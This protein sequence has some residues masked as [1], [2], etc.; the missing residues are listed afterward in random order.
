LHHVFDPF[1]TTRQVGEGSGLGL[2]V[3]YGVVRDHGGD[4]SVESEPAVRT[5]FSVRLPALTDT[6]QRLTAL[7]AHADGSIAS[8]LTATLTGWG[9]RVV[10]SGESDALAA[11]E[12]NRPE[13]VLLDRTVL[14]ANLP[15]WRALCAAMPHRLRFLFLGPDADADVRIQTFLHEHGGASVLPPY[16]LAALHQAIRAAMEH[17]R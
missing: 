1:F 17:S 3:S 11:V 7:V 10:A 16:D 12:R 5:T 4:I 2:S 13:L 9:H 15:G 6:A 14:G 8:T